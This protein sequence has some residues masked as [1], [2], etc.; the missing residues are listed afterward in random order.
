VPSHDGPQP[1]AFDEGSG[2]CD[3]SHRI[4]SSDAVIPGRL[5]RPDLLVLCAALLFLIA[6]FFPVLSGSPE[7]C[8]GRPDGDARTQFYPWR[9]FAFN[10]VRAGRFPL[11]NPYEFLG[12]PFV[13]SLQ[14]GLFYP[15]NWLCAVL[16]LGLAINVGIV[17]NLFLSILFTH[18]W[19]R[20]LGISWAGAAVAAATYT[21]GAPQFLRIFEGHWSFLCSMTWVPCLFLAA[22]LLLDETRLALGLALGAMAVAMQTCGGNPQYGLYSGTALL[23]YMAVR[24]VRERD[25]GRR[26]IR[27]ACCGVLGVYALGA[28]LSAVQLLPAMEMLSLSARKGQLSLEW[29][30]QYSLVPES[31]LTLLVPDFFGSDIGAEYWGRFNLWEMSAY[32]G[33]VA[34]TLAALAVVGGRGEMR[35]WFVGLASL[36]LLLALG[37]YTPLQWLLYHAVPGYDLFRVWARFLALFALFVGV[38]AGMGADVLLW[39]G[40]GRGGGAFERRKRVFLYVI[41]GLVLLLAVTGLV[42]LSDLPTVREGWNAFMRR[43]V[44]I[45]RDQRLYLSQ[46]TVSGSFATAALAAAGVSVARSGLLLAGLVVVMWLSLSARVRGAWL[47]LILLFLVAADAWTFC[48]RYLQTF[49]PKEKGLTADAAAF[50]ARQDAPWRYARGGDF[51]LPPGDG[52][53]HRLCS[54]EGVQPNVPDRFRRLY[55]AL[56][57]RPTTIQTTFYM[58][59]PPR[60]M[61]ETWDLRPFEMLGLRYLVQYRDNVPRRVPGLKVGVFEDDRFRIDELARPFPR[62]WLVH[63]VEVVPDADSALDRVLRLGPD[64]RRLAVL[65]REMVSPL[66]MLPPDANEPIPEIVRYEANRVVIEAAPASDALLVLSDLHYP[67]WEATVDGERVPVIRVNYCMRGVALPAGAHS[68]EFRYRPAS[69]RRGVVMSFAGCVGLILLIGVHVARRPEQTKTGADTNAS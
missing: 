11:W 6:L 10:E 18:L 64:L 48:G 26:L 61:H 63:R 47:A 39:K 55:W 46:K 45:G 15:T 59:Y 27:R 12:M 36:V 22:E 42:L 24:L 30:S 5:G 41:M 31:L 28:L 14:S 60:R 37:K 68:I 66:C 69:F 58:L 2:G 21:F 20:R 33:V 25:R 19:C 8:L 43:V 35:W 4:A 16:P 67:G 52:M 1:A 56:Q 38:L 23:V 29:I 7:R 34:L 62:A 54:L 40:G 53:M 3:R 17:V 50:L 32:V 13:A 44:E 57:G 65:E 9:H 49:D 51:R